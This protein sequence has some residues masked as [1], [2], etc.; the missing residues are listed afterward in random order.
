[1]EIEQEIND[2]KEE[3]AVLQKTCPLGPYKNEM[4][5]RCKR[6]SDSIEHN[7]DSITASKNDLTEKV[8]AA[9]KR[10]DDK[11]KYNRLIMGR[12]ISAAIV[13][14]VCLVSIIGALQ[15][16][17]VSHTEFAAHK[18]AYAMERRERAIKFDQFIKTYSHDSEKRDN[19]LDVMINRQNDIN[20]NIVEQN[21]LLSEQLKVIQTKLKMN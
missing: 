5:E 3:L 12:M 9:E 13:L 2:L 8:T 20:T 17:K 21:H 6:F 7:K 1:M 14:S 18:D 10:C 11:S 19:K 15:L 4:K 16:T